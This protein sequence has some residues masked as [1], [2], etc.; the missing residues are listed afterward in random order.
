MGEII[1]KKRVS[2]EFLGEDYKEAYLIFKSIPLKD[3][4]KYAE[5]ANTKDNKAAS[6]LVIDTLISQF[7]SG[8]FP[9]ENGELF[10]V[11]KEQIK[12]FDIQT[13]TTAFKSLTGQEPDPKV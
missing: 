3:F 4:D 7:V 13:A 9:D 1:I 12:E 8:K 6:K 10:D 11:T 5:L 2:L